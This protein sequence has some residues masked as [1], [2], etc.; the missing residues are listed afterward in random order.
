MVEIKAYDAG[1]A[2]PCVSAANA[3]FTPAMSSQDLTKAPRTAFGVR[4]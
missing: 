1:R 2:S 3:G 4:H